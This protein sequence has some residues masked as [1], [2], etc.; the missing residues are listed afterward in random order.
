MNVLFCFLRVAV[1]ENPSDVHFSD[2]SIHQRNIDHLR[3][4]THHHHHPSWTS[5]LVGE[6]IRRLCNTVWWLCLLQ[7][8]DYN[9]GGSIKVY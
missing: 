6:I 7:V 5:R 3:A 8:N 1:A 2:S 4:E 9:M